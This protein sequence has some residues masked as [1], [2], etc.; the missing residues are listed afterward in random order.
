MKQSTVSKGLC[1][2]TLV[3]L[4]LIKDVVEG[5]AHIM[6]ITNHLISFPSGKAQVFSLNIQCAFS[7]NSVVSFQ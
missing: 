7:C 5:A 4:V 3:I 2:L 1:G 6:Q